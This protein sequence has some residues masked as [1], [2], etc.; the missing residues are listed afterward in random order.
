MKSLIK[1]TFILVLTILFQ[2]PQ[3]LAQPIFSLNET[4]IDETTQQIF[5]LYENQINLSYTEVYDYLKGLVV[6]AD[7]DL[8]EAPVPWIESVVPGSISLAWKKVSP[9]PLHY[10][11]TFLNLNT[12]NNDLRE[13]G[14][15]RITYQGLQ[16][17]H[18]FSFASVCGAD[19]MGDDNTISILNIIIVDLDIIFAAP[20]SETNC[21]CPRAKKY[22]LYQGSAINGFTTSIPWPGLCDFSKY[23]LSVVGHIAGNPYSS[24]ITFIHGQVLNPATIYLIPWCDNNA[25]SSTSGPVYAGSGGYYN[26]S[27]STTALTVDLLPSSLFVT[28][29]ILE[30]CECEPEGKN[31]SDGLVNNIPQGEPMMTSQHLNVYPNPGSGTI[32]LSFG[33]SATSDL[34]LEAFDLFGKHVNTVY[35][36]KQLNSGQ[37]QVEVDT[38][39][40]PAGVYTFRL[41]T[42]HKSQVVLFTKN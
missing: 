26:A 15:T 12:G 11:S 16:G 13:T 19:F 1:Y 4:N 17:L 25:L 18:L 30:A 21:L 14:E 23:R 31:T 36:Q 29:M 9:S 28:D 40:W 38:D 7:P 22:P 32:Q 8:C 34:M 27:F 42:D 24:D 10:Q 3:V 20:P 2:S 6:G 5:D 35:Q 33:L 39:S 37:Y 41:S